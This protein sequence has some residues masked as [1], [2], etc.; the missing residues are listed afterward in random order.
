MQL[1][2]RS[3]ALEP[4][5]GASKWMYLGQLR[6]GAEAAAAFRT[7]VA[8]LERELD[9]LARVRSAGGAARRAGA[10]ASGAGAADPV[11]A[12][13]AGAGDLVGA[14]R[15]RAMVVARELCQAFCSLTE[16]Y[17]TDL[18]CVLE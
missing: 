8:I 5:V 6:G 3:T 14:G 18:W 4:D 10:P 1:L 11:S 7:G 9:E 15:L 12:I 16:L 17:M 13:G 2:V